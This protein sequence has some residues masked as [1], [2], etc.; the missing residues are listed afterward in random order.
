MK[1]K[2]GRNAKKPQ[3]IITFK[4]LEKLMGFVFET[5]CDSYGKKRERGTFK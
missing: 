5:H 1:C 4:A 3:G 2:R